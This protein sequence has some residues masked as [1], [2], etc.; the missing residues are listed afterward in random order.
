[1]Q[2]Q[3]TRL[4]D[5]FETDLGA[6]Y[7]LQRKATPTIT[8]NHTVFLNSKARISAFRA[9]LYARRGA[10]TPY[11]QPT[12]KA[13]FKV[14]QRIEAGE[15]EIVVQDVGYHAL[16]TERMQRQDIRVETRKG[17]FFCRIVASAVGPTAGTEI[18]RVASPFLY[19]IEVGDVIMVSFIA[20][21]RLEGDTVE[22][23]W[24]SDKLVTCNFNTRMLSDN[25]TGG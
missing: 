9:W 6:K 18:L 10:A 20:L 4:L 7:T 25:V 5:V 8:R 11:W 1:V 14:V 12:G 3:N 17:L 15:D 13:D 16:Y 19:R 2:E 24:K 21:N 23:E 22:L